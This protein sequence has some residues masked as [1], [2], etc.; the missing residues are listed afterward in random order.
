MPYGGEA[1]SAVIAMWILTAM[2][3]VFVVLRTYTR[4]YVVKSSGI[5]DHVYNLAFVSAESSCHTF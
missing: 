5:D 1:P 3:F 4:M 2:T